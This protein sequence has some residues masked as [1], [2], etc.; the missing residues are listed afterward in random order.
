M[1][2]T[3]PGTTKKQA[4]ANECH[5]VHAG[6]LTGCRH[7]SAISNS[8]LDLKADNIL[9]ELIDQS[10]LEAFTKPELET[11]SDRKSV[12]GATVYAS[13]RLELPEEFGDVALSDLGAAVR[14]DKKRNHD[15]QPN[16]Y[17]SPKVMLMTEWN[18]PVD[19][20]NVGPM[21]LLTC[22]FFSLWKTSAYCLHLDLG[23]L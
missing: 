11:P 7:H 20:W 2:W 4:V 1:P 3:W 14:G 9:Q 16:V 12:D 15:A 8:R 22:H 13:R 23:H 10:V 18:Y 17:R 5:L 21:A 6:R 19:T